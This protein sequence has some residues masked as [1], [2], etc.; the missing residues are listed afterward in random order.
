MAIHE[1]NA[2]P[3]SGRGKEAAHKIRKT[4]EIP[5]I[6]YGRGLEPMTLSL[7]DAEFNN[8]IRHHNASTALVRL[9][10]ESAEIA[11]KV[12]MIREMQLHHIERKPLSVDFMAIDMNKTLKVTVPI[13]FQGVAKGIKTGGVVTPLSREV[14]VNCLPSEIPSTIHCDVTELLEGATWYLKDLT[15][16]QGAVLA[17]PPDTPLIACMTP[18]QVTPEEEAA[19]AKAAE[20]A[21]AAA[22]GATEEDAEGKP[23]AADAKA[24]PADPKA[25]TAETRPE[26]GKAPEGKGKGN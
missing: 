7:N 14:D 26:R 17:Q 13:V 11:S 1:L 8:F 25:K 4:G 2:K 6:A 18:R 24:K 3:R 22:E 9:K 5:A 21:A 12:F 23:K 19:A 15:L 20:E 10:V 16:P